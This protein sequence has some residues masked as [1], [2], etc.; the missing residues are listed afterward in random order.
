MPRSVLV[1]TGLAVA[2]ALAALGSA[3]PAQ[4]QQGP[5]PAPVRVEAVRKEPVL[6]RRRVTGNIRPHERA[7]VAAREAG[8]VLE[9]PVRDGDRVTKGA[10][11]ARLDA[12]RLELEL[13]VVTAERASADTLIAGRREELDRAR[14]DLAT[15]R[16][17]AARQAANPRELRD[18][19]TEAAVAESRLRNAE[20]TLGVL[21]ARAAVLRRRVEDTTVRAPFGGVVVSRIAATGGW[22]AE[23][24]AVAEMVSDEVEAWLDVPQRHLQSLASGSGEVRIESDATGRSVVVSSFRA[25]GDVDPR[26]R[27]FPLVTPLRADSGLAPGTSVVAWVPTGEK[28]EHLTIRSDAIL[29]SE[30][31]AYV[32]VAMPGAAGAPHSAV[33]VP[34]E[35]LFVHE[36]RAAVRSERLTAGALAIVE[37]NERLFPTAPVLPAEAT[38]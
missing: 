33:P 31:G 4:A 24:A 37:G 22:V 20:S 7:R 1:R 17:L 30:T 21:D 11:L 25:L 12:S 32:Y 16:D 10:V 8:V 34:V 9:V 19:E 18:A 2:V 26:T 3:G 15:V 29:R 36:G 23:G 5:P 13:A 28:A 35:V 38:K 27:T 14:R 6:E